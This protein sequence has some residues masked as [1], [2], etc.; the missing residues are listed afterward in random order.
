MVQW[1]LRNKRLRV[2]VLIWD[3]FGLLDHNDV[4]R[5]DDDVRHN[6]DNHVRCND[7]DVRHND[8][9]DVKCNDDDVRCND[10]NDNNDGN[11]VMMIMMSDVMMITMSDVIVTP[12]SKTYS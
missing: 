7:D 4:R 9:N 12:L 5:N 10:D 6:D 8:D 11:N 1:P 3:Q 2:G